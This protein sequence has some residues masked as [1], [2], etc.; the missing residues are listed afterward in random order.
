MTSKKT[1][2]RSGGA[3]RRPTTLSNGA[4]KRPITTPV[5]PPAATKSAAG[6][7]ASKTEAPK[8]SGSIAAT[9]TASQPLPKTEKPAELPE[10][11]PVR[12]ARTALPSAARLSR[13]EIRMQQRATLRR[14]QNMISAGIVFVALVGVAAIVLAVMANN[15]AFTPAIPKPKVYAIASELPNERFKVSDVKPKP[16]P[17][18]MADGLQYMD[19]KQG[20][21][22]AVKATDTLTVNYTGWLKNGAVFDSSTIASFNHVQPAQFALSGVIQ[23]WQEGLVGMKVGGVRR[24]Y[25]PSAL[26]YGSNPPQGSIIQAGDDLI[27]EVELISIP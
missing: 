23:G 7:V 17:T 10:A 14:R 4:A 11:T 27:F 24:L 3:T 26:A 21:G 22:A 9:K 25:I 1:A 13:H 20:A 15:G 5:G 6:T 18:K 19:L 8:N 16:V 2:A 12:P